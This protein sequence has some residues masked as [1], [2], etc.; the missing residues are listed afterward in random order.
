MNLPQ[1]LI[2]LLVDTILS[3]ACRRAGLAGFAVVR[4]TPALGGESS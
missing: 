4:K 3:D 1:E 2:V